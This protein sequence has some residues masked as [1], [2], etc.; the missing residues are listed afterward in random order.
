VASVGVSVSA[1]A[2]LAFANLALAVVF[3]EEIKGLFEFGP[4]LR[5]RYLTGLG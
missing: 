1:L 5:F 3:R 2:Y 4:E